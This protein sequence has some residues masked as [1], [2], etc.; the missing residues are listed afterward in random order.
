MAV[1]RRTRSGASASA[2][3]VSVAPGR[4]GTAVSC[5]VLARICAIDASREALVR[6]Y[7]DD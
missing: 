6:R 5:L 1:R 2:I 3:A 7:R 4:L